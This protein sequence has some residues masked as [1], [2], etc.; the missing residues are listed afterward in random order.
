M[1]QYPTTQVQDG[2]PKPQIP[3]CVKRLSGLWY[4]YDDQG[5]LVYIG[6]S[7]QNPQPKT[8]TNYPYV[9]ATSI[10]NPGSGFS[11]LSYNTLYM[12]GGSATWGNVYGNPF[13]GA[14]KYSGICG[15]GMP[16]CTCVVGY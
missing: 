15:L 10:G 5:N 7:P 2:M 9:Y 8:S 14:I 12:C 1:V 6:N 4:C 3:L 11:I 16:S 13:F